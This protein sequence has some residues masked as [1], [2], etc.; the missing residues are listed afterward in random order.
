MIDGYVQFWSSPMNLLLTF[1]KWMDYVSEKFG[2]LA[3]WA[4]LLAALISAGNAFVRY[5]FDWSSNSLL[6]I[7]WY[8]FGWMVMVGAPLVLKLNEHVRVDL[9]YGKLK[10]NRPVYVD[11]FGL[12]FFLLPVMGM[13]AYMCWPYFMKVFLTGEMSQ[14][15]GGL[16]RWPVIL[17]LPVGFAMVFLQGVAEIIKRVAF[18]Q[19]KYEMDTHYEKPVQ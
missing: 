7:Q 16:I 9:I 5:G 10:G 13:M 18:L 4:V 3:S 15:A 8:M 17:C 19:G 11:I 6:E 14:N 12:T 2:N 1:V